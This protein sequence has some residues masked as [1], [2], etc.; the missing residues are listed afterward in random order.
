MTHEEIE[1][2]VKKLDSKYPA[3]Y[4]EIK[5]EG[6]SPEE[7]CLNYQQ[8]SPFNTPLK[9]IPIINR[10]GMKNIEKYGIIEIPL[11]PIKFVNLLEK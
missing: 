4:Y 9:I 3:Y 8:A 11:V 10:K 5:N 1:K 6:L 2:Y 7:V